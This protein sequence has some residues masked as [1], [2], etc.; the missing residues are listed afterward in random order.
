MTA[1]N[2]NPDGRI[3]NRLLFRRGL[4]FCRADEQ[5]KLWVYGN[6]DLTGSRWTSLP[7]RFGSVTGNFSL[8]RCRHLKSL[9]GMPE[10]IEGDLDMRGCESL[11]DLSEAPKQVMGSV[12]VRGNPFLI[13]HGRKFI[14]ADSWVTQGDPEIQ[15]PEQEVLVDQ[16][17]NIPQV[18]SKELVEADQAFS[19]ALTWMA[20]AQE[21]RD[22]ARD[23]KQVPHAQSSMDHVDAKILSSDFAMRPLPQIQVSA[24]PVSGQVFRTVEIEGQ[25]VVIEDFQS[26]EDLC[27]SSPRG[28]FALQGQGPFELHDY[29]AA[30]VFLEI[31]KRDPLSA[32]GLRGHPQALV[33]TAALILAKRYRA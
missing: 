15:W 16:S 21:D 12:D 17:P 31:M 14:Q 7:L 1:L 33:R 22:E 2:S 23:S 5:G 18:P 29:E 6:V 28:L 20:Q 19:S 8:Q 3:T 13:D 30:R 10:V 25:K 26:V 4:A 9:W 32:M 11:R 27:M 24:H